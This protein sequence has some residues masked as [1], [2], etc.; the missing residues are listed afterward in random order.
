MKY[1]KTYKIFETLQE[2]DKIISS[3]PHKPQD[4]DKYKKMA[5]DNGLQNYLGWLAKNVWDLIYID[6]E[7]VIDTLK[8]CK[9]HKIDITG[10]HLED[11]Y[12]LYIDYQLY[13]PYKK[14]VNK[15]CPS[16]LRSK[17][18]YMKLFNELKRTSHRGISMNVR[19]DNLT[20]DNIKTLK[21]GSICKT[22]DEWINLV[23]NVF[24]S[25]FDID[26]V[27]KDNGLNIKYED[28]EWIIFMPLNHTSYVNNIVSPNWC[29]ISDVMF[30]S[31]HNNMSNRF[32]ICAN[33]VDIK[34]SIVVTV[35]KNGKLDYNDFVNRHMKESD[36]P[37][38]I[39]NVSK[40]EVKTNEGFFDFFKRKK[41]VEVER[42]PIDYNEIKDI[43][44]DSFVDLTDTGYTVK[45]KVMDN[46]YVQITKHNERRRKV[47]VDNPY[48][49]IDVKDDVLSF[50]D[51]VRELDV[52]V[53]F[54]F[55]YEN[56]EGGFSK[57]KPTYEDFE[58]GKYDNR[59]VSILTIDLLDCLDK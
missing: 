48:K 19:F 47:A 46:L 52:E 29:L 38:T 31:Y 13:Q 9:Q 7:E 1:L 53:G 20:D 57:D 8:Y 36:V 18:T 27:K 5:I 45:T 54:A 11:V 51:R 6:M 23:V 35:G 17:D 4:W 55:V 56:D 50:C 41:K 59:E 34:K 2:A 28:N 43:V 39:L 24:E 33:K 14:F 3:L 25:S 15:W 32:L 37:E 40:N 10:K 26:K 21:G 49:F 42:K 16:S 30:K 58:S 12:K 22:E 44:R